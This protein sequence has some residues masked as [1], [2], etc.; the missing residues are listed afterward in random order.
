M[1]WTSYIF[2][3]AS[4]TQQLYHHLHM[5]QRLLFPANTSMHNN[6]NYILNF[7]MKYG[8]SNNNKEWQLLVV[9]E[10]QDEKGGEVHAAAQPLLCCCQLQ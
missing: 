9:L 6:F 1:Q 2:Q 7:S 3:L 10:H 8:T 5:S 4:V